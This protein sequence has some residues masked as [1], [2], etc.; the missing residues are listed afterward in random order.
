MLMVTI[1]GNWVPEGLDIDSPDRIRTSREMS[2]VINDIGFLPLCKNN[3]RGFSVEEMTA[4]T[5]W[6]TGNPKED[7]WIW[8]EIIAAEGNIAYGKL[9]CGRAGF[10][11]GEWYPYFASYRRDGYD[12]DSR[13]EDGLASYRAK[14]VMDLLMQQEALPS[15]EIRSLGGF[16]KGGETGFEGIMTALQMQTYITVRAFEKRRN[17]RNE[18]YGW[19]IA[20]YST[21]EKLFGR[22]HVRSRYREGAVKSRER[23]AARIAQSFPEAKAQDIIKLIK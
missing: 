2:E 20:V 6:W 9:F 16:Y 13:Y 15:N 18:E 19:P 5:V 3:I 7:P 10:I 4:S 21:S 17:K 12:F 11:S 1:D 14:R 8:R 22:E 23:I